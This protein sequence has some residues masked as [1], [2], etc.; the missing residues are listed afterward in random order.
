MPATRWH[1]TCA[2]QVL[3]KDIITNTLSEDLIRKAP[4]VCRGSFYKL[5]SDYHLNA[6]DVI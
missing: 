3:V 2:A 1:Q 5:D 6:A 4:A